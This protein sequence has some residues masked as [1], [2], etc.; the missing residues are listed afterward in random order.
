MTALAFALPLL[1]LLAWALERNH[2]RRPPAPR[3][4]LNGSTDVTDRDAER[5][6][7]ELRI[8]EATPAKAAEAAGGRHETQGRI[9]A[10]P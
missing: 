2:R 3:P 8:R 9:T 7:A 5:V 10:M 1:A 4:F 6:A